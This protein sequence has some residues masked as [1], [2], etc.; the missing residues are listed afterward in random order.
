MDLAV[1]TFDK[2]VLDTIDKA[3]VNGQYF[4][5]IEFYYRPR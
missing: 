3:K 4:K 1:K 5:V 2:S